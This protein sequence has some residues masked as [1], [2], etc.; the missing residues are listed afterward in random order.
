[1]AYGG[2]PSVNAVD[3]TRLLVGDVSTST[4]GQWLT[5]SDYDFF[6]AQSPN[7][8]VQAQL[9]AN[10]LAAV[11]AGPGGSEDWIERTVG[12]LTL[13][14]SE[15]SGIAAEFRA[16]SK[17]YG[18][19]AASGLSPYAGGISKAGKT[20]VEGN[21]DRVVPAFTRNLFDN[22]NVGNPGRPST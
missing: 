11:F 16:L 20:N 15:S 10:S 14:R 1:M 22:P 19:M 9:A 13:K 18:R 12:D 7:Q 6:N 17:K 8:Y 3:R 5:N 2:S 4:S 21:T